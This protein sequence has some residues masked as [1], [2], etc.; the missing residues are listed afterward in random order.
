MI[1]DRC[2]WLT[3]TLFITAEVPTPLPSSLRR[4]SGIPPVILVLV[5]GPKSV[6]TTTLLPLIA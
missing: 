3:S 1:F 6:L 5:E 2:S 4:F